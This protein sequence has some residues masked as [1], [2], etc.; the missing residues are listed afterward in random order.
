MET[1]MSYWLKMHRSLTGDVVVA[2]CDS[3]LVGLKLRVRD[4]YEVF[5]S[6][7]FYMGRMVDWEGVKSAIE[8]A[9]IINLLG[10]DVVSRAISDGLVCESACIEVGGI[11]HVQLFR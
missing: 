9:T 4:G 6:P 10:N 3:E 11:K 1:V 7:D 8:G 5:V 2:V